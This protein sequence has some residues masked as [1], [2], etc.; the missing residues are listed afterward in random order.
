M[1][2]RAGLSYP[3]GIETQDAFREAIKEERAMELCFEFTRRNDLI[4]WGELTSAMRRSRTYPV[5]ATK[6]E[7]KQATL[8]NAQGYL[9]VD[10][11]Y[12]YFPIPDAEMA[13]NKAI[14]LIIRVGNQFNKK[15]GIK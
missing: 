13:V 6:Q 2:E 15:M 3:S 8:N 9:T 14:T 5:D 1:R 12:N 4:R 7:W 11:S 10:E